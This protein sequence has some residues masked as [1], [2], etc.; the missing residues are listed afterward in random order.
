MSGCLYIIGTP[1]GNLQDVTLRAIET[2]KSIDV[3]FCE[4][5]RRTIKL[6]NA[7]EIKKPLKSCPH[8]RE[9][10]QIAPV[11]ERLK[12]GEK[13]GYASDAGMPGLCDPGEKLVKAARDEGFRV[14][15]IGGVSALS[16]FLAGLGCELSTFRFIGFLPARTADRQKLFR[17]DAHEP[18]VFFES[19]HR[20]QTTLETAAGLV[21]NRRFI[22]AKE[23][24]KISEGFFEGTPAELLKTVKSFKGEWIGCFF[25]EI[26]EK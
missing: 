20:L 3:L 23:L 19:P 25:P 2:L 18:T 21:P 7:F 17:Q 5:T 15:I 22:L 12:A 10:S 8:F 11:L 16:Y 14:E 1:I 4:D 26:P 9:Y 13:V 24:S 6:L